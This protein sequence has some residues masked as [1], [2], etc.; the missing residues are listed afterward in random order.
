MPTPD[1]SRRRFLQVLARTGV[2]AGA[3]AM[4]AGCGSTDPIPAGNIQD[5]PEGTLRVVG[6]SFVAIGRDSEGIY[7]MK[8][9]CTHSGCDISKQGSVSPS[10]IEC[11]CH[12]SRFDANGEVTKGPA[13]Q[14]LEHCAVEIDELGNLTVLVDATVDTIWRLKVSAA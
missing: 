9:I 7:S 8:L 2:A 5:L 3:V 11:H 1:P 14:T 12:G 6:T 10:G 13:S 4:G